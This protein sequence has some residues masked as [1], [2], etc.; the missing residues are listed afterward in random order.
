[1]PKNSDM[2]DAADFRLNADFNMRVVMR[3]RDAAW[4]PSPASGVERRML[5]RIGGEVARATSIVRYAPNSG[6]PEHRHEG[7]EE[8]F[9]LDGVFSDAQGDYGPGF[10]VRNPPGTAHAPWTVPGCLLFVKLRQMH[11]DDRASLRIDTARHPWPPAVNRLARL[12]L[13]QGV[14]EEV[15]LYRLGTGAELDLA[16]GDG[17][18]ALVIDGALDDADDAYE[19]GDWLR[20]PGGAVW[21]PRARRESRI[22]IKRGAFLFR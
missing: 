6:F 2:A 10:Y 19:T 22:L 12:P 5:D 13:Y 11:A 21:R 7:G 16:A 8:F 4:A 1:M 17:L 3:A 15:A 18:E 14:G 9:V 20:L